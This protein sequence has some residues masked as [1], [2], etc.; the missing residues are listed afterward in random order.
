MTFVGNSDITNHKTAKL[1]NHEVIFAVGY[2][3]K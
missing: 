2:C 1:Y 3:F